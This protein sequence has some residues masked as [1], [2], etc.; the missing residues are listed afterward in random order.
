VA[1][2]QCE[3]FDALSGDAERLE[4]R[5]ATGSP[6]SFFPLERKMSAAAPSERR[7]P[8]SNAIKEKSP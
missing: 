1:L 8:T 5:V 6:A 3:D 4:A 7:E 2:R